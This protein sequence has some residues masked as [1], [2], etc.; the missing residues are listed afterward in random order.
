MSK[1]KNVSTRRSLPMALLRSREAVM[2]LF[3]PHLALIGLTEQQ[4]RVLR[5]LGEDGASEAGHV[6]ERACILP[7]SLSRIIKALAE[8]K[9]IASFRDKADGRRTMIELTASGRRFLEQAAPQSAVIYAAIE[10][11]YGKA[12]LAEML[13]NLEQ[14]QSTLTG[15]KISDEPA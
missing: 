15:I 5:V 3:R 2:Q 6:A 1:S 11:A 9:F 4:W 7:P 13:D 14:L 10:K 8:Q 12:E